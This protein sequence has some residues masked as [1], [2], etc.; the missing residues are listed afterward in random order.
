[1]RWSF[2]LMALLGGVVVWL[3]RGL[4]TA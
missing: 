2:G 3:V 1:L 4:R